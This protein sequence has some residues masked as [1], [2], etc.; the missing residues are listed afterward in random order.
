MGSQE[1]DDLKL[2]ILLP[3]SLL[4]AGI[5]GIRH[6]VWFYLVQA[7]YT[8]GLPS[9]LYPLS[10]PFSCTDRNLSGRW[11]NGSLGVNSAKDACGSKQELSPVLSAPS[12]RGHPAVPPQPFPDTSDIS[13]AIV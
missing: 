11:E 2:L 1:W 7:L 6:H 3:P 13:R 4:S 12:S 10:Q 8:W 9:P 5:T